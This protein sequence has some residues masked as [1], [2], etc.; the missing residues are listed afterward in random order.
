M[1]CLPRELEIRIDRLQRQPEARL[2]VGEV[3]VAAGLVEGVKDR[4]GPADVH[5]ARASP[6]I[7]PPSPGAVRDFRAHDGRANLNLSN[8]FLS[9]NF[10]ADG[11]AGI[12]KDPSRRKRG[13][14]SS[15]LDATKQVGSTSLALPALGFGSAHLGELYAKV[16]EAEFARHAGGRLAGRHP[17]L[18]HGALVRPRPLRAPAR[19]LPPHPAARRVQDHHQGRPPALPPEDPPDFDRSPWAGGLNFE[20]LFDYSYDGIMRSYA[21]A[22]QRLALDTVDALVIHD[23]DTVFTARSAD[24]PTRTSCATAA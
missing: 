14:M 4:V 11:K 22:L 9:D 19:R 17:L 13:S 18:R 12:G 5:A 16:D 21:Q 7:R 3:D 6:G 20:V 23:L 1:A 24:A 15:T 2:V 10:M 8:Q